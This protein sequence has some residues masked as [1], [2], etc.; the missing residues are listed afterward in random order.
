MYSCKTYLRKVWRISCS[1]HSLISFKNQP[2]RTLFKTSKTIPIILSRGT[3]NHSIA[4][5]S[6]MAKA[7]AITMYISV[8]LLIEAFPHSLFIKGIHIKRTNL[9]F[10]GKALRNAH[11]NAKC[12]RNKWLMHSHFRKI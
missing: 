5:G 2:T 8:S 4:D 10:V 11:C 1:I 3:Q 9:K 7:R 12:F 6:G